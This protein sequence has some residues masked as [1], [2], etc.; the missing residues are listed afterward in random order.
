MQ[1]WYWSKCFP[2]LRSFNRRIMFLLI[3]LHILT[4]EYIKSFFCSL[5]WSVC[6]NAGVSQCT[7]IAEFDPSIKRVNC[8][9]NMK[10]HYSYIF[11]IKYASFQFFLQGLVSVALIILCF[12]RSCNLY[13]GYL[14]FTLTIFFTYPKEMKG[15]WIECCF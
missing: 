13:I 14:F 15:M 1:I 6:L 9:W 8:A 4:F 11:S 2:M 7:N 10:N 3:K 12:N 5:D